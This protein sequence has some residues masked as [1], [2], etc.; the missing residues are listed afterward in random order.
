[1]SI[2]QISKIQQRSGDLVDLPQLD[3]AEFGFASDERRLFIGKT[4]GNVE[5]VE[6]LTAYSDISFSQ[7]DG[8]IGNLNITPPVANGEVLVFDGFD[9]VNRGGDAGGYINLGQVSNVSIEGGAVGYVL[10]TD[11]LGNL[12]WTPKG[13]VVQNIQTI[14][15]AD[16]GRITLS[17]PY[18]F[19]SGMEIILNNIST[20]SGSYATNLN[21][22][23]YFLKSVPGNLQLYDLYDNDALTIKVN[24]STYGTYPDNTGLVIWNTVAANGGSPGGANRSI[25]FNSEDSGFGGVATF[26]YNYDTNILTLT[27]NAILGNVFA[28]SGVVVATTLKGEGGNISNVTAGNITGQ[29]A[30]ALIAGTV[31]TAAQPNITSVGTL[32]S[33]TVAGNIL[34]GNVYANSGTIGASLLTGALTTAAQPNITSTGMLSSLAVAGNA[35]AANVIATQYHVRSVATGITAAG[36]DQSTA[37]PLTKE[38]NTIDTVTVPAAQGVV[39]PTAVAGIVLIINNLSASSLKVYPAIGGTINNLGTNAAYP[40]AAGASLQY[41]AISATQWYTVGASY[42]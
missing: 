38:I 32:S 16:P 18:P 33:L 17:K 29:V 19:T 8:A 34:A 40:H 25:Q 30:N 26:T 10:S 28:N 22:K 7:I 20:S 15:A 42:A 27:G 36:S 37:T 14:S 3:E 35:S 4:S 6:I 2:I 11:G 41:Y 39:L 24:T 23:T 31:T 5:N 9:W 13:I 21:G 12:S 1:M